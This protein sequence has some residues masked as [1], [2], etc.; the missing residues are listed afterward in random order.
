MMVLIPFYWLLPF[1]GKNWLL[2]GASYLIYGLWEPRFLL[3][4]LISTCT[5]FFLGRL[6]SEKNAQPQRRL[7]L[8]LSLT[9]NLGL[10]LT[11]KHFDFFIDSA[12]VLFPAMRSPVF[13]WILAVGFPIGISFYT[14]QTISYTFDIY[15]GRILP[16][17]NFVDFAL[18]V[19]FF[20]QLVAGPIERANRL[21]PQF[22]SERVLDWLQIREGSLL[23]LLGL[24]KKLCVASFTAAAVKSLYLNPSS[25]W[26]LLGIAGLLMTFT[27]YAD[28]SGYSDIARGLG[29][30][31]GIELIINFKPFVFAKNPSDF[32]NRWHRSLTLWIRDYLFVGVRTKSWGQIQKFSHMLLVFV[33]I[34]LWHDVHLAWVAFGA[35][36]AFNILFYQLFLKSSYRKAVISRS[37]FELTTFAHLYMLFFFVF[38]G[39]CHVFYDNGWPVS[40]NP[41]GSVE[42]LE[43][44]F[45]LL[46]FLAPVLMPLLFFEWFQEKTGD[47]DVLAKAAWPLQ[48]A[49]VGVTI[50]GIVVLERTSS[51]GFIYFNF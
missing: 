1:R 46:L 24:F 25:N 13:D 20:P 50:A 43:V 10:L 49:F 9:I 31:L 39:S 7:A 41:M 45:S 28:F 36:H 40:S 17:E 42:S 19:S 2:L 37:P 3:L 32:W 38:S 44:C 35:F 30:C 26:L 29:K 14:F 4:L 51:E 15:R 18:Y 22:Q 16:T 34:G 12:H 11:F 33:L 6:A 27:V 23:V 21:L 8:A 48:A 47:Y 5:D